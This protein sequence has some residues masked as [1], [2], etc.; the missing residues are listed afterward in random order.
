MTYGHPTQQG[1]WI[2]IIIA[3]N[4]N[5]T[6]EDYYVGAVVV[7]HPPRWDNDSCGRVHCSSGEE[8][9]QSFQAL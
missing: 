3:H 8:T 5:D 6:D 9:L 1:L 2:I 7:A 4:L